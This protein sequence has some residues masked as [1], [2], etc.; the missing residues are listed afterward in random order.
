MAI[1][2]ETQNFVSMLILSLVIGAVIG[3]VIQA[4]FLSS[5]ETDVDCIVNQIELAMD[6]A[7][8]TGYYGNAATV[9]TSNT[10]L[11]VIDWY[12]Q[13]GMIAKA[14]LTMKVDQMLRQCKK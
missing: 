5:G 4:K 8:K 14:V 11:A 10:L 6:E 7:K 3:G 9:S 2:E 1:K 13:Y 12:K